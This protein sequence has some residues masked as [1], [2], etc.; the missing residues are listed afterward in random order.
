MKL[1][2]DFCPAEEFQSDV[3]P[4]YFRSMHYKVKKLTGIDKERLSHGDTFPTVFEHFREWCGEDPVFVT[5]G[6]DD[7]RIMEQNI[8]IHDLDWDWIADWINLQLIYNIQTGGDKNQKSL[9]TAMEHFAIEQTRVAHDALG[10]AYNTA[11]VCSK[12]DFAEGLEQY[13]NATSLL[14]TR[15]P[16][17]KHHTDEPDALEHRAFTGYNSRSE[18]FLD[19][20]VTSAVCP[21]CGEPL[22]LTRWVNQGDRRYMTIG[23][24][25]EHRKFLVRLKFR[26]TE[27]DSWSVNRIVYR[28][29]DEMEKFY[30]DKATQSRRRGRAASPPQKPKIPE[31]KNRS[32]TADNAVQPRFLIYFTP[33]PAGGA[34]SIT[35]L[36]GRIFT[37]SA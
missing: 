34:V 27:N 3:R 20:E 26:K 15:L 12:L 1:D 13:D 7:R 2:D 17:D 9:A 37:P 32:R 35:M 10:D 21:D 30:R 25:E 18:A 11:L 16:E 14:A 4:I 22:E 28:A 31:T 24:C 36:C 23:T 33:V 8:I 19:E 5:W 6:Y 29:D